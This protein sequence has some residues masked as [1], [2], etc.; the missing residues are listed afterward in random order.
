MEKSTCIELNL[1][2]GNFD[3]QNYQSMMS[4]VK[5]R[6]FTSCM[7]RSNFVSN[8]THSLANFFVCFGHEIAIEVFALAIFLRGTWPKLQ[9]MPSKD[10]LKKI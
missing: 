9:Y 3:T 7:N 5:S 6:K 1:T 8:Q 10:K 2:N 4:T